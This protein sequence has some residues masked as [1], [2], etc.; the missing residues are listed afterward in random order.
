MVDVI[1]IGGGALAAAAA[2]S[3]TRRG[4]RVVMIPDYGV[5]ALT[6]VLPGEGPR[7]LIIPSISPILTS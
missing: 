6:R 3:L 7:A 5:K 4:K 2:V 1:L